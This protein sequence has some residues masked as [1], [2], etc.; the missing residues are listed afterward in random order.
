MKTPISGI[1]GAANP[2]WKGDKAGYRALHY[3]L[4][5]ARGPAVKCE[6]CGKEKT[7]PKSVQWANVSRSYLRDVDDWISL[8]ASCH[9]Q[10]DM[11]PEVLNKLRE[12]IKKAQEFQ[13]T[14]RAL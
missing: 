5:R 4:I 8:C 13:R 14:R 11:T 9:T 2:M 10:Y 6:L 3:W 12:N 1:K 7:T